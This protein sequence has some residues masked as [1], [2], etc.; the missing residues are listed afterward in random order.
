MTVV[1]VAGKVHPDGLQLLRSRV[2]FTVEEMGA[3]DAAQF[4]RQLPT[5]DALLIRTAQLPAEAV[6]RADRL[7]IVSR[8][9]VGYDN[10]PLATLT[11]RGV[12]LTVIGNAGSVAVA[13]HAL[14]LMLALAKRTDRF[15]RS[16]RNGDWELRNRLAPGD[17]EGRTLLI[18]GLGRIGREVARRA[19]AFDMRILGYDP[20]IGDETVAPP[21]VLPVS[22]WRRALRE[23]DFVTLHLPRLAATEGMIG[24]AEL[25]SMK[26][27][28]FLI[29]TSRGGLVDEAALAAALTRGQIAGAGIDTLDTEPPPPGHPL[30]ASDRVI[31]SPH[32]AGLSENA[33]R[34]L[35][36]AAAANVLAAFDGTLDPNLVVNPE[37]LKR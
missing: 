17:L 10:I 11:A 3:L 1:L 28:A 12:P 31:L 29:N 30:L 33:A 16:V 7:R 27:N 14:M 6:E 5:A 34:R 9:G 32:V 19:A 20:A 15:D 36:L 23:A 24:A 37:V 18:L 8:H 21:G 25:A 22:D 35:S 13:E 26:P 2:G 4:V